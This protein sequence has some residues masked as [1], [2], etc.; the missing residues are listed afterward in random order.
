M[1]CFT[2][3]LFAEPELVPGGIVYCDANVVVNHTDIAGRSGWFVVSPV[4]HVTRVF[5]MTD[6]ELHMVADIAAAIDR[7]L[8]AHFG[9]TR[10]LVASLGWYVEDHV[11]VHVVPTFGTS[12]SFGAD[13]FSTSYVPVEMP[14]EEVALLVGRELRRRF[15][16]G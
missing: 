8:T 10:T 14:A 12:V 11:H 3:R 6:V 2:C 13:V 5:E 1:S 16:A 7:T 9:A 15:P 4:R